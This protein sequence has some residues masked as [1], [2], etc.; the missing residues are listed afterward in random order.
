MVAEP[1]VGLRTLSSH[2]GAPFTLLGHHQVL[3]S[4]Q[5]VTLCPARSSLPGLCPTLPLRS[6]LPAPISHCN[7]VTDTGG[8]L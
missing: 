2:Y 4:A 7:T 1:G 3:E 5:R 6:R 8:D